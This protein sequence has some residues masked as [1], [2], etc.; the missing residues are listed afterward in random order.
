V[1]FFFLGP[2]IFGIRPG[3]SLGASDF[4]KAFAPR[5]PRSNMTGSFVYVI[6]GAAGHHKIGVIDRS[7]CAAGAVAD[8]LA[9]ATCKPICQQ[10]VTLGDGEK[11]FKSAMDQAT[12]LSSQAM[13]AARKEAK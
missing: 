2:R 3:I 7:D 6:E 5:A 11:C 9:P 4:R 12:T 10:R 13:A 1:R 8:R